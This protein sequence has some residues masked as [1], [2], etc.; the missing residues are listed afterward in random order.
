MLLGSIWE[1]PAPLCMDHTFTVSY[2]FPEAQGNPTNTPRVFHLEKT[3]KRPL[4]RRFNVECTWC[5]CRKKKIVPDD[6]NL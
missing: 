2:F 1:S 3:W 4:P 6:G 5:V